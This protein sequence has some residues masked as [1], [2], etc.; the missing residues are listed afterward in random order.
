M[1]SD[2][3][4][5]CLCTLLCLVLSLFV[6]KYHLKFAVSSVIL[7]IIYSA[8]FYNGLYFHSEYGGSL[9]WIF[10]IISSTIFH[11]IVLVIYLIVRIL[12]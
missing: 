2:E 11:N 5:S 10:L 1:I 4:I 12:R 7:C 3:C 9:I 6:T 8:Y